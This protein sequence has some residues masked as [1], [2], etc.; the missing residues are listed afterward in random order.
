MP[1]I[2][3]S[4][5]LYEF[6]VWNTIQTGIFFYTEPVQK[7]QEATILIADHGAVQPVLQKLGRKLKWLQLTMVGA[8]GILKQLAEGFTPHFTV[9][10]MSGV[11]HAAPMAEYV[12]GHIIAREQQFFRVKE[13]QRNHVWYVRL[14]SLPTHLKSS[15]QKRPK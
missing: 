14:Q 4:S 8:E 5:R 6:G 1:R 13:Y 3:A 2:Y 11:C 9:T 7:L 10:H 12:L 15:E